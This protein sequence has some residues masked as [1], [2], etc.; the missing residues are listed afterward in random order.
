M[1]AGVTT[2]LDANAARE[3]LFAEIGAPRPRCDHQ[4]NGVAARRNAQLLVADPGQRTDVAGVET[5]GLDHVDLGLHSLLDG[6]RNLHAQNLGAVEQAL[7]VIAQAEDGRALVGLVSP[8]ALEG[9]AAVVQGVGQNVDFGITPLHQL[10]VHP[11][12]SVAIRHGCGHDHDVLSPQNKRT[13]L[14]TPRGKHTPRGVGCLTAPP[15]PRRSWARERFRSPARCAV[16][17]CPCRARPRRG[18]TARQAGR[19]RCPRRRPGRNCG[20]AFPR[21]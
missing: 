20:H 4:M 7:G 13:I 1:V 17:C 21:G 5:V 8:H 14:E 10:A 3:P 16:R 15:T 6:E 18:R 12:F 2:G 19:Q 11:D 9:A